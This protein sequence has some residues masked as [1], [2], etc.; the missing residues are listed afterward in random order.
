[1]IKMLTAYTTEVDDADFAVAE[2]L[3][4]LDLENGLRK[5]SIGLVACYADFMEGGVLPALCERLPFPVVGITTF[6]AST[7]QVA[8][9]LV[10]TL[11]V[12]TS[13]DVSFSAALTEPL[14]EGHEGE[15]AAT[16]QRALAALPEKPSLVLSY[17]PM[18]Q[19][20]GGEHIMAHVDKAMGGLPVF[21]TVCCDES[22]A[23]ARARVIFNGEFYNDRLGIVLLS[24]PVKPRFFLGALPLNNVQKHQA[25]ITESEGNILHKV[26]GVSVADYLRDMGLAPNDI[27]ESSKSMPIVV[28][29]QDGTPP[30]IRGFY[31]FTPKGSAICGG[32]MPLGATF[33]L[34][35]MDSADILLSSRQFLENLLREE[36][37]SCILLISCVVRGFSLDAE[38]LGELELVQELAGESLPYM[39]CYSG[40]EIC[41]VYDKAG[42]TANRFHNFSI[43]GCMF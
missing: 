23:S 36:E 29:Y 33:A 27:L 13:D 26:N 22:F 8:D 10:L 20:P 6:G 30:V 17:V 2:I 21:G 11:C 7:P 19:S 35:T 37:K 25:L 28:D 31:S 40:G 9:L 12:L 39:M 38:P 24:G 34:S 3:K 4:Q 43:I 32:E 1:M 14:G 15:I 18:M 16:C 42:N 5:N 41:P